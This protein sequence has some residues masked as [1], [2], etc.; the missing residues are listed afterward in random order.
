[1]FSDQLLAY[2]KHSINGKLTKYKHY[3]NKKSNSTWE[4]LGTYQDLNVYVLNKLIIVSVLA[5]C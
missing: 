5:S 1:M 2:S 3:K 4:A